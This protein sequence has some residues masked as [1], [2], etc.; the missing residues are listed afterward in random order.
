[1]DATRGYETRH[2]KYRITAG[3]APRICF[4]IH[5]DARQILPPDWN[6]CRPYERDTRQE[7]PPQF[8]R[9]QAGFPNSRISSFCPT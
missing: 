7:L 8:S 1:M 2:R 5:F 4:E 6:I 9:L 3:M